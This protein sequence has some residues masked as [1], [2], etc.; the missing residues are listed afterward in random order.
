MHVRPPV[1]YDMAGQERIMEGAATRETTVYVQYT[2][3]RYPGTRTVYTYRAIMM[4][5]V[6]TNRYPVLPGRI[7]ELR[8]SFALVQHFHCY[9]MVSCS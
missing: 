3:T 1:K 6:S 9:F 7:I 4:G 5:G 8:G 2:R